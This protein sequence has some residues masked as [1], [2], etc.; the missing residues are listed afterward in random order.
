MEKTRVISFT[1]QKGGVGKSTTCFNVGRALS[2]CGLNVLFIDSDPQ[3]D[4]STMSGY[5]DLENED[6]TL[7]EVLHGED[8]NKA[9][10]DG[11]GF[12][13][14]ASDET[15]TR[16]EIDL[17]KESRTAL[18]DA[19]RRLERHFDYILIDC[20]PSLNILTI[21]ALTASDEVIIPVQ[22]QYLPLRGVARLKETIDKTRASL[23]PDLKIGGVVVTFYNGRRNLDQQVRESLESAFGAKVF[24]TSISTSV[25]IAEAPSHGVSIFEYAPQSKGAT[26]YKALA[27]E[28][29]S[30][31]E[32]RPE[33]KRKSTSRNKTEGS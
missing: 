18:R 21:E 11:D 7:Y 4:L 29:I 5:R 30:P 2:L 31:E 6:L 27:K 25:K 13:I 16:G 1:N 22:A 19:L 23:N 26:Q 12:S 15:L 3:G 10:K 33:K 24:K 28:I 8:I 14:V 17:L 9:I 20:P 32:D